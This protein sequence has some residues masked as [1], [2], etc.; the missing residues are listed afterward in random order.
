LGQA[1]VWAVVVVVIDVLSQD[2][3]QMPL[4]DDPDPDR[5]EHRI[6]SGGELVIAIPYQESQLVDTL[7]EIHEYIAGLLSHPLPARACGDAG[8]MDTASAVLDES[9]HVQAA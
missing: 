1:P 8:Q 5:G 3:A 4:A 6:E 7:T 9:Q 2:M